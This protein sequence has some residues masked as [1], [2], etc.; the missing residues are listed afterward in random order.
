[1]R[2]EMNTPESFLVFLVVQKNLKYTKGI[3]FKS[4]LCP[5]RRKKTITEEKIRRT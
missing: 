5:K 2:A 1:M 3:M 4:Y